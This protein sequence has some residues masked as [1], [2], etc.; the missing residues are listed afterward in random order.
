MAELSGTGVD[1]V[2]TDPGGRP[3]SGPSPLLPYRILAA[4]LLSMG[5]I[6]ALF[7]LFPPDPRINIAIDYAMAAVLLLT[8]V[9]V[10]FVGPRSRNGWILDAAIAVSALVAAVGAACYPREIG[11][12]SAG[13]A[14]VLLGAFT[15]YF[16]GRLAARWHLVLML[17]LFGTGL[18]VNPLFSSPFYYLLICGVVSTVTLMISV[19]SVRLRD[20]AMHDSLTGLLNRRG[21]DVAAHPAVAGAQRCGKPVTVGL[22]DVDDFKSYNDAHGHLAGDR[23]LTDLADA[24]RGEV[25]RSDIVA[26]FGGDEFAV[27]LLDAR[28][29][30]IIDLTDRVRGR[31]GSSWSAGFT[32]WEDGEDLY[33]ALSRADRNLYAAKDEKRS[34]S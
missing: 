29:D 27:V 33:D 26:R 32:Q 9:V 14:L 28:E 22:I 5:V 34:G 21:L 12:M 20:E 24:W 6:L 18:L 11:Q 19:L 10:R 31:E 25:R 16:R 7:G 3:A 13:L 2:R 4:I 1:R 15:G 23:V 17:A 30:D 8:G